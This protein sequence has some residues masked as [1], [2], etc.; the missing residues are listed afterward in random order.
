MIWFILSRYL[1][2]LN[3]L[4]NAELESVMDIQKILKEG[5]ELYSSMKGEDAETIHAELAECLNDIKASNYDAVNDAW[6][7]P[8]RVLD[9]W[10]T[11]SAE[12]LLLR[13][14]SHKAMTHFK[15]Y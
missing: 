2:W 13:Y 3:I 7:I 10:M 6:M 5:E 11:S 14:P 8:L 1:H 12:L 4:K 15:Y 9:R